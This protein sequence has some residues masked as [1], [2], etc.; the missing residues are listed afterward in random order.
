MTHEQVK[1]FI[2]VVECGSLSKA[3]EEMFLTT[4]SVSRRIAALEKDLNL[5]LFVKNG[6]K[7]AL[8]KAGE[9]IFE[10]IKLIDE[11]IEQLIK[12]AR[13]AEGGQEGVLKLGIFGN[14][15][16]GQGM[17]KA[18]KDFEQSY[19]NINLIITADNFE[20]LENK[21]KSGKIDAIST[22]KYAFDDEKSFLSTTFM[23]VKTCFAV[24]K[25][26][27]KEKKGDYTFDDIKHIPLLRLKNS[28]I[29]DKLVRH[30]RKSN[31]IFENK[32]IFLE[33]EMEYAIAVERQ[34][35]IGFLDVNSRILNSENI[36]KVELEELPP[37]PYAIFWMEN[38]TNPVLK[39]WKQYM[40]E[41]K[42]W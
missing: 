13:K 21:L 41:I 9:V 10:E 22:L 19:P 37:V 39:I 28:H 11:Q 6:S 1:C 8:T 29:D 3:A 30:L 23:H 18:L 33:D 4:S 14:Q 25:K 34:L 36:V 35:G 20:G 31:I 27:L 5:K 24:P 17:Y 40:S 38:N 12:R 32:E 42:E 2:K 15:E 26:L 7:L 16:V